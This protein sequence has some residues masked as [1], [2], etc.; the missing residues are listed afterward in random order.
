MVTIR[1]VTLK[2]GTPVTML[3]T[4]GNLQWTQKGSDVEVEL[5][6]SLAGKYAYGVKMA[7][8]GN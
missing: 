8:A 3:G 5:P 6:A 2:A 4:A 7:G 1:D